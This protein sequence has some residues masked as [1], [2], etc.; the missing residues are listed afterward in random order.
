M[1]KREFAIHS[2]SGSGVAWLVNFLL[3]VDVLCYWTEKEAEAWRFDASRQLYVLDSKGETLVRHLPLF[4]EKKEFNFR[5]DISVR[6]THEFPN[7]ENI[8]KKIILL[9][10][11]GR[12]VLY[13]QMKRE[14]NCGNLED[15]L[16][17]P[18]MP[19]GLSFDLRPPD[20]WALFYFLW[21]RALPE[22][23]LF[24]IKFEDL[25]TNPRPVLRELLDFLGI[26]REEAEISRGIEMS[27]FDRAKKAEEKYKEGRGGVALGV[28][29]RGGQVEEWRRTYGEK[30]LGYFGG[31]PDLMLGKLGYER[32][33]AGNSAIET[34]NFEKKT[35]FKALEEGIKDRLKKADEDVSSLLSVGREALCLRW[36]KTLCN[37]R[38][39]KNLDGSLPIFPALTS[40]SK[41]MT[42]TPELRIAIGK[43]VAEL[44]CRRQSLALLDG[45]DDSLVGAAYKIEKARAY[46]DI[47]RFG[48]AKEELFA[49]GRKDW[50]KIILWEKINQSYIRSAIRFFSRK[51]LPSLPE[52]IKKAV[53]SV[54]IRLYLK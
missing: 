33:K 45:V 16:R 31:F 40:A 22:S 47:W 53:N 8:K 28:V 25:K 44:G 30:E 6:W 29:N 27:S 51:I 43:A 35:N 3:E 54:R 37:V 26:K 21:T 1:G 17:D 41:L 39:V 19:I 34:D 4:S 24:I 23:E 38:N 14:S 48:L 15:M 2:Y 12:D 9:V 42:M 5:D 20:T 13:S 49:A 32:I 11:D 18:A 7:A 10:R 52:P 50:L 46:A 36:L